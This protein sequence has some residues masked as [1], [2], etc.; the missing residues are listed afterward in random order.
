MKVGD[1]VKYRG[2]KNSYVSKSE[3]LALIIEVSSHDS[4]YHKRV[5]VMWIGED[6][7]IQAKVI[8]TN[9]SRYS[10]W[11]SPK[12]FEVVNDEQR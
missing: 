6:I 5:R 12:H 11:C 9:G 8:S 4:E 10:S 7:P 1:L 2:W 3:P